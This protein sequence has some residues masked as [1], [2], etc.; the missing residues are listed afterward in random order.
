VTR[1]SSAY[2]YD[3]PSQGVDSKSEIYMLDILGVGTTCKNTSSP[4]PITTLYTSESGDLGK[5]CCNHGRNGIEDL[6]VTSQASMFE[7]VKIVWKLTMSFS[8]STMS[9]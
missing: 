8:N 1:R 7:S 9:P 4:L 2:F 3:C 6:P 5:I